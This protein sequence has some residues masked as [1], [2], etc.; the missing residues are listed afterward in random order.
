METLTANHLCELR[1]DGRNLFGIALRYNQLSP[2]HRERFDSGSLK[3][4]ENISLNIGHN[5][6][7]SVA[8]KPN[9]GLELSQNLYE[10]RMK[11]RLPKIPAADKAL[12]MIQSGEIRG[13]SIE[14][15]PRKESIDE[16]AVRV[17]E[18]AT[19]TGIGLVKHPSYETTIEARAKSG[20]TLTSKLPYNQS[21]QCEC[22]G[23][24]CP[25]LVQFS[26]YA[27]KLIRGLIA[28]ALEDAQKGRSGKDV[29][30]IGKDYS[31]PLGSARRGTLRAKSNKKGLNLEVD[32]PSG[33]VGDEVIAASE[34]AGIVGRPLID[35]SKTKFEDVNGVR[36]IEKP[37]VRGFM[38][39]VTDRREGWSDATIS[40]DD[41][42]QPRERSQRK[43]R[44]IWL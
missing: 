42:E 44:R 27:G 5:R 15:L 20:R 12:Q 8:H 43:R 16:N 31:K 7:M 10:V 36:M 35:Y 29:L 28:E 32:I 13:L 26:E 37:S 9:G 21:L 2:S 14:F 11:A 25:T 40:Y 38:F 22:L 23:S 6:M 18:E 1:S 3:F 33:A 19:L 4:A 30:A 24:D 17:I 34:T 39:S 41:P